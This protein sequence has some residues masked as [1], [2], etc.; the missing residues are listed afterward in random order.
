MRAALPFVLAC[1]LCAVAVGAED[2]PPELAQMCSTFFGQLREGKVGEAYALLLQGSR[3][4]SKLEDVAKLE[5]RTRAMLD[6]YGAVRGYDAVGAEYVGKNLCRLTYL[7]RSDIAPVRW[8]I[9]F[10]RPAD[11]W[12]VFNL[13]MD[14]AVMEFF[15]K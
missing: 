3:I 8:R 7:T 5:E 10:Y 14:D 1:A 6:S 11:R 2:A 15:G 9:V 13:Q 12:R 4:A